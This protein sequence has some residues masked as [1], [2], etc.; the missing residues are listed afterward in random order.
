ME[1]DGADVD[2]GAEGGGARAHEHRVAEGVRL[3]GQASVAEGVNPLEHRED[4]VRH[5]QDAL[6]AAAGL[7]T[8]H[9]RLGLVREVRALEVEVVLRLALR[10]PT[11]IC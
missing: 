11:K 7:R 4:V 3:L 8:P 10:V 6:V 2:V 9:M 1:H 5:L